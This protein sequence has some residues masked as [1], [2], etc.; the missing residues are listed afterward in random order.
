MRRS[1]ILISSAAALAASCSSLDYSGAEMRRALAGASPSSSLASM[2]Q[3]QPD[4]VPDHYRQDE[5]APPQGEGADEPP[6]DTGTDPRDFRPKFMPYFRYAE[7]ENGVTENNMSV[8]GLMAF[9]KNF[10]M[11]YEL[12]IALERE[13]PAGG[14]GPP[15][16]PNNQVGEATG[17]G[18]LNLRFFYR[19][20]NI[21]IGPVEI[22]PLVEMWF[23]TANEDVLGASLFQLAPGFALV[24]DMGFWPYSFAALMNFYQF[25][26]Y[27][28]DDAG[29]VSFYKG[30]WF[31][32]F[33]FPTLTYLMPEMQPIYDF[34]TDEFSFWIG[35]EVG[36]I[37][38]EN[39]NFVLYA[40]PGWGI[41]ND[42][43]FDRDFT[44]EFGWRWFF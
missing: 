41:D 33:P 32:M 25:D 30:R 34:E 9:A 42:Q 3:P 1:L 6:P 12:P 13:A 36:Q 23:P 15:V 18:D 27:G 22:M 28:D 26:V 38:G 31:F 37:L 11:T 44:F 14:L 29:D 16:N 20:P 8:F 21:A 39:H 5:P 4:Y 10:A 40:K 7:L 19:D 2:M 17:I 24:G 35:P 43:G